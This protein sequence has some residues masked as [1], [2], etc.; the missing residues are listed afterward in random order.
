MFR[1]SDVVAPYDS[2]SDD[3]EVM[4]LSDHSGIEKACV[5]NPFL[6]SVR[7]ES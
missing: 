1:E 3:D 6:T 4:V 2:E 7:L 5:E